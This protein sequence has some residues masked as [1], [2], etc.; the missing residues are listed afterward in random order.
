MSMTGL[1][2]FYIFFNHF[3]ICARFVDSSNIS[4]KALLYF[5]RITKTHFG[6]ETLLLIHWSEFQED[7]NPDFQEKLVKYFLGSEIVTFESCNCKKPNRFGWTVAARNI[8]VMYG[9]L[10]RR[11]GMMRNCQNWNGR[12]RILVIVIEDIGEGAVRKI[13]EEIW[14]A[15]KAI[16]IAIMLIVKD[17]IRIFKYYPYSNSKIQEIEELGEMFGDRIPKNFNGSVLYV[18]TVDSVPYVL[19]PEKDLLYNEGLEV[20]IMNLISKN[21]NFRMIYKESPKGENPWLNRLPDGRV[22]GL[23]GLLHRMEAD[24][25]FH[26]ARIRDDRYALGDATAI[27]TFDDLVWVYPKK[28]RSHEWGSLFKIFT[29]DLWGCILITLIINTS[30]VYYLR[31]LQN[32]KNNLYSNSFF[33]MIVLYLN[34]AS[35]HVSTSNSYR[36][37]MFAVFLFVLNITSAYQSYLI[38]SLSSPKSEQ[39]YTTIKDAVDNGLIAYLYPSGK[40]KY[41][42]TDH[43][44]WN[45]ILSPGNV[46][47]T[48]NY[49]KSLRITA[50]NKTNY[51]E[52]IL[53][54]AE[55]EINSKY[56]DKEGKPIIYI[57]K[58]LREPYWVCMFTSR[59]HPLTELLTNKI[60]RLQEAGFNEFFMDDIHRKYRMKVLVGDGV[61]KGPKALSLRDLQGAFLL[62]GVMLIIAM[63]AFVWECLRVKI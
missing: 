22:I 53:K 49:T 36:L 37:F 19:K 35:R 52:Y 17:N 46:I 25:L 21:L 15:T 18:A 42:Q 38:M 3:I 55:F 6:N 51:G 30:T 39:V 14:A 40:S 62:M 50:Y 43:D 10:E 28:I 12:A 1:T 61:E 13:M 7:T 29:I 44:V 59:G 45:K 41:N 16:N 2:K 33:L 8:V 20:R 63:G 54:L 56:L 5:D 9:D 32:E 47:W 11:V 58:R 34:D 23:F 48:D 4:S 26:G 57:E 27:H 31:K 60:L 24:I